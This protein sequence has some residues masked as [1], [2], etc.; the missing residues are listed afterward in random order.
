MREIEFRGKLKDMSYDTIVTENGWLT[1]Y[2]FGSRSNKSYIL[3]EINE[4][5][6]HC[7]SSYCEVIPETVGQ[8]V[9]VN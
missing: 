6:D 5:Y 2:Y 1:G 8:Y 7:L 9:S 3:C 4:G